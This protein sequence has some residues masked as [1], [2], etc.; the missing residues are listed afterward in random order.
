MPPK[1]EEE[2][3]KSKKLGRKKEKSNKI[4]ALYS[5]FFY[6]LSVINLLKKDKKHFCTAIYILSKHY[7]MDFEVHKYLSTPTL[8]QI[9]SLDSVVNKMA[10]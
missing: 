1:R 3:I 2:K 6:S 4:D 10:L 5:L 9:Y 7:L 8:L